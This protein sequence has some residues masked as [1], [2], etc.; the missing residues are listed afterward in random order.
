MGVDVFVWCLLYNTANKSY[1]MCKKNGP[2][3]PP[4]RTNGLVWMGVNGPDKAGS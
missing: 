2:K 1:E 3:S 4:I